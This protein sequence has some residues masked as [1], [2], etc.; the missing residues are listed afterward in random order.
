[1]IAVDGRTLRGSGPTGAQVHLLAAL[2]Q[3]EQIGLAQINV[4][5]SNLEPAVEPV[6][7]MSALSRRWPAL[8]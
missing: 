5:R 8:G 1:M 3:A 4:A 2:N 6:D 7:A